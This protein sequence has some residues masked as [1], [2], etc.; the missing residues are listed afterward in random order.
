MK[1]GTLDSIK[2][3][4][5]IGKRFGRLKVYACSASMAILN[6]TRDELIDGVDM[7]MG[8]VQFIDL[9][10]DADLTLYI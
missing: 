2:E 4:I 3:M 5:E 8:M 6:I 9:V 10:K 7:S 1:R